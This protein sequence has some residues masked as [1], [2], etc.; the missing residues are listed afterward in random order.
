M[1]DHTIALCAALLCLVP[2]SAFAWP[3]PIPTIEKVVKP[4]QTQKIGWFVALDP[5]CRSMGAMTVN[6]IE[7]PGKGQIMIDQGSEYPGFHPANPRSACNKRK[8]P[9]TRLI[10]SAPP[11]AADDDRFAVELVGP[12]GDVQRVRYHVELH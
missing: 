2:T 8:V 12:L 9:A 6:L 4:G 10:Y 7:P 5:T 11:G 1:R 3:R